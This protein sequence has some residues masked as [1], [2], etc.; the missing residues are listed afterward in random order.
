[1]SLRTALVV[2]A[3]GWAAAAGFLAQAKSVAEDLPTLDERFG[4]VSAGAS[5]G[6]GLAVA[7]LAEGLAGILLSII[8]YFMG[9]LAIIAFG[10]LVWGGVRY[11]MSLGNDKEVEKAK[12]IILY[13]VIG[14][15]VALISFAVI[16]AVSDVA[17][18]STTGSSSAVACPGGSDSE[19]PRGLLCHRTKLVCVS[20]PLE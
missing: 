7:P 16:R 20:N 19:C 17:G 13:A 12:L 8:T 6:G 14:V 10:A 18:S 3:L 2:S 9:L 1:M 11:I 5:Q 15:F 4:Q